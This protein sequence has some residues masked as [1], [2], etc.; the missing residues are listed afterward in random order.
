MID[1]A[2]SQDILLS[3]CI[4]ALILVDPTRAQTAPALSR[5]KGDLVHSWHELGTAAKGL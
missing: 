4:S 2:R 3:P 1:R 5:K